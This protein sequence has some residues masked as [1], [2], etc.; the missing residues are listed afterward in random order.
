MGSLHP[1]SSS[2]RQ[3]PRSARARSGCGSAANSCRLCVN[4]SL[5]RDR[6]LQTCAP[7][8]QVVQRCDS[9][10]ENCASDS[11]HRWVRSP[12]IVAR[13]YVCGCAARVSEA[14]LGANS[15]NIFAAD[16][17]VCLTLLLQ[18]RVR[19]KSSLRD[20]TPRHVSCFIPATVEAVGNAASEA[21]A[22]ICLSEHSG[23]A[24]RCCSGHT[25]RLAKGYS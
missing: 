18:P 21:R 8:A 11:T 2:A 20:A 7:V 15:S 14:A 5:R 16:S 19:K 12:R 17:C 3:A 24:A 23:L 9:A 4:C 25:G 6:G 13:T 10:C 1:A 22:G